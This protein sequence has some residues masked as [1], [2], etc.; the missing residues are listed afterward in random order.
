MESQE[1]LPGVELAPFFLDTHCCQ[2]FPVSLALFSDVLPVYD[3]VPDF[4]DAE[5]SQLVDSPL[6]K[7]SSANQHLLDSIPTAKGLDSADYI[8]HVASI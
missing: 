7:V 3:Q 2:V 1:V 6:A 4:L 8:S 5:R